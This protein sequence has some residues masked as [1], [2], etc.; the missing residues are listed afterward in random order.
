MDGTLSRFHDEALYLER[1]W[2]EDFFQNLK[3]FEQIVNAVNELSKR[4]DVE[5]FV[6]S[7]A[8]EGEPPYCQAQKHNWIDK[9]L[10][11]IDSEHRIFTKVGTDK[12]KYILNGISKDDFLC[13][14]YNKNLDEWK[15]SG[16]TSIKCKNNINHR[17][18]VDPLWTGPII[19]N[20]NP[21]NHITDKFLSYMSLGGDK[22][23]TCKKYNGR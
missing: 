18:L 14:D 6:L 2:E 4:S 15:Q 23:I 8:I 22:T 16:G 11:N 19:E 21:P 5:V 20:D 3:P 17:G 7:A 1:M 13:D 9:Y 12:T 10:P